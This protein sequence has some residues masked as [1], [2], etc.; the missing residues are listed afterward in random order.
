[1]KDAEARKTIAALRAELADAAGRLDAA[2]SRIQ[3]LEVKVASPKQQLEELT[4]RRLRINALTSQDGVFAHMPRVE[5]E[6][7][8]TLFVLVQESDNPAISFIQKGNAAAVET[9]QRDGEDAFTAANLR[10]FG[11][12]GRFSHVIAR[13]VCVSP[14]GDVRLGWFEL[15]KGEGGVLVEVRRENGDPVVRYSPV[16][17]RMEDHSVMFGDVGESTWKD[18]RFAKWGD[19]TFRFEHSG[20]LILSISRDGVRIHK[21]DPESVDVLVG[22]VVKAL[23]EQDANSQDQ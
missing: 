13:R 12:D 8:G 3:A 17:R 11:G 10:G 22:E 21:L 4:I 18:I 15:E 5:G 20:N 23:K 19:G 6:P 16:L 14:G 9:K 2:M 7:G 1:M